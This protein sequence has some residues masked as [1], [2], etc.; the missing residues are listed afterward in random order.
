M[1]SENAETPFFNGQEPTKFTRDAVD[2]L[3][4]FEQQRRETLAFVARLK[5]LDLF[6]N[7]NVTVTPGRP[8][9]SPGDPVVVA[10]YV[11][12]SADKLK[13]L[14]PATL[15]ELRDSGHLAAMYVHMHSLRAWQWLLKRANERPAPATVN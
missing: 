13:A 8:D 3:S 6:D 14:A 5:E 9:G 11:A 2:F 10:E 7:A 1:V 12:V 15:A 4:S